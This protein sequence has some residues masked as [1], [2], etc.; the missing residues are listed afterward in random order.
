MVKRCMEDLATKLNASVVD[1][2]F[3][4]DDGHGQFDPGDEALDL[5]VSEMNVCKTS[6]ANVMRYCASLPAV[7]MFGWKGVD[8]ITVIRD[9]MDR[10]LVNRVLPLRRDEGRSEESVKRHFCGEEG[11]RG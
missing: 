11:Q 8:K 5:G 9:P 4:N 2:V 6:E 7:R 1:N 10:A 3:Y